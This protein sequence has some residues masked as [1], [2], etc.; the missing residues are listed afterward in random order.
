MIQVPGIR[1]HVLYI[2]Q[3][4]FFHSFSHGLVCVC[5]WQVSVLLNGMLDHSFRE[6]VVR[7]NHGSRL[8]ELVLQRWDCLH[9]WWGTSA[10]TPESKT[11]T[12]VLLSKLL[13]VQNN[14][15]QL[16]SQ[17]SIYWVFNLFSFSPLRLIRPCVQTQTI[18]LFVWSS[19]LSPHS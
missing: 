16:F 17:F 1:Y 8:V 5:V 18:R 11:A 6:R 19:P 14:T 13:Q 7:K 15:T 10:S 12:L 9:P 2:S 4:A 3:I